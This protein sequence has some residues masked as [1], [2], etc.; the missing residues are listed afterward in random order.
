[1]PDSLAGKG[2]LDGVKPADA[3]GGNDDEAVALLALYQGILVLRA[4]DDKAALEAMITRHLETL[5]KHH[6]C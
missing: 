5:E 1:M 2:P 4:G 3:G 6:G